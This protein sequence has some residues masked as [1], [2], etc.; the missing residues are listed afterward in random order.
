MTSL[1]STTAPGGPPVPGASAAA[2]VDLPDPDNPPIAI[3]CGGTGARTCVASDG[4]SPV[5]AT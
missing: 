3:S 2:S 4:S 1:R 5:R